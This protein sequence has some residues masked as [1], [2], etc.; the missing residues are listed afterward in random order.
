MNHSTSALSLAK[1]L[2]IGCVAGL[3]GGFA[4]FVSIFVIDL[5][6]GASQGTFYKVVG[7]PAGITG[8]QATLFGMISHMLTATL[9]GTVFGAG[10]GLHKLLDITTIK[11]GAV[12]GIVSSIVVFVAFFMPISTFVMIPI[13]ESS[14]LELGEATQ[15][16]AN[17][18]FILIGSLELH[19]VYGVV[20]GT[21]FAIAVQHES[22]KLELKT[23]VS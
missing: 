18:D 9:I 5:S 22:K 3:V 7:L 1:R 11:K 17:I 19:I 2:Q 12:A 14:S 15:L 8:I 13:L 21:F 16:V 10:S 23:T 6:L 4:I 20:M